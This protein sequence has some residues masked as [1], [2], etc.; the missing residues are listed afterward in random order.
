VGH[1]CT[2]T[3]LAKSTCSM[4]FSTVWLSATSV[5]GVP[6]GGR[7]AKE[8]ALSVR[9]AQIGRDRFQQRRFRSS[10]VP[11]LASGVT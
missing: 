3:P 9:R 5:V 1:I 8:I 2:F 11:S 6:M 4:P 7:S 10:L